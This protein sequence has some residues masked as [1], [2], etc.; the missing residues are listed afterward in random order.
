MTANLQDSQKEKESDND[1]NDNDVDSI[2]T[3]LTAKKMMSKIKKH[4][5]EDNCNCCKRPW[6]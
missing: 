1:T 5:I 3:I 2:T 6:S 4:V